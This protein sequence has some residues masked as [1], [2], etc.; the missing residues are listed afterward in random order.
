MKNGIPGNDISELRVSGEGDVTAD[1]FT[2]ARREFEAC[3]RIVFLEIARK[4]FNKE[5]NIAE[6]VIKKALG[7]HENYFQTM[8]GGTNLSPEDI[9]I[10]IIKEEERQIKFYNALTN[11]SEEFKKPGVRFQVMPPDKCYKASHWDTGLVAG[12]NIRT[13]GAYLCA[14]PLVPAA[15]S[16]Y[17]ALVQEPVSA[18]VIYINE[19]C[20]ILSPH[21]QDLGDDFWRAG[22]KSFGKMIDIKDDFPRAYKTYI[23]NSFLYLDSAETFSDYQLKELMRKYNVT[24]IV[25]VGGEG[26]AG[27]LYTGEEKKLPRLLKEVFF[28]WHENWKIYRF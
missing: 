26:F 25:K 11:L 5:T 20:V 1:Y 3:L 17:M 6:S 14:F 23:G 21:D 7:C 24:A 27:F 22:E 18:Q 13:D 9:R 15:T 12:C 4:A 28:Q 8:K 2:S 16:C 10:A 19:D